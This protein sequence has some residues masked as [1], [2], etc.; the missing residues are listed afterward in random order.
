MDLNAVVFAPRL[1]AWRD[2]HH[3]NAAKIDTASIHMS[4]HGAI[5]PRNEMA[6]A[7]GMISAD[8]TVAL[9]ARRACAAI[10]SSKFSNDFSE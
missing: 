7:G 1:I 9:A 2:V 8:Q 4:A 6:M 3:F 10:S 5:V